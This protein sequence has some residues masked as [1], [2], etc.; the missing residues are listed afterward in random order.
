MAYRSEFVMVRGVRTHVL[1]GG[2]GDALLVLHPEYGANLWHPFHDELVAHFR[3]VAP[4]HLGFGD[5]E[6]PD[7]L[8]G[9]DDLVL[10]YV[11]LLD[12]LDMPRTAVL[13]T[14]LGGWIAA[15]LAAAYPERISR[16]ILV[17]AAGLKLDA[18]ARYDLFLNQ[19]EDTLRHLFHDEARAAQLLPTEYGPDVLVRGYREATTLARLAWNPYLYNP[20]LARR[21]ARITAPTLVVWGEQDTFLPPA[22]GEAFVQRIP[23]ATLRTIPDCGHLVP[24]EQTAAFVELVNHF[25]V[26]R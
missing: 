16:L 4:D 14:S 19:V 5:S 25:L 8:D 26:Q 20:K 1:H 17:G 9:I 15:E 24:Y 13:G 7:W 3:V 18:V 11:D 12:A 21:L 6:R 2:R 22:Y 23:G 10:H